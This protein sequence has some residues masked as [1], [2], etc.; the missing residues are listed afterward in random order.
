[1]LAEAEPIERENAPDAELPPLELLLP[2]T[3]GVD[4][5]TA[6]PAG[7]LRNQRRLF[8]LGFRLL[9]IASAGS[10]LSAFVVDCGQVG[11]SIN[12]TDDR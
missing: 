1:M 5:P 4:H 12:D 11:G 2:S 10:L 3:P 9:V 8:D 6:A 7:L